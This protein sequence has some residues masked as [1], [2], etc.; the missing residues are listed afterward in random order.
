MN[1]EILQEN[2]QGNSLTS[3]RLIHDTLVC[4]N[5]ARLHTF[6]IPS[7]LRK[8]CTFA[9]TKYKADLEKQRDEKEADKRA[10]KRKSDVEEL[11]NTKKQK[12]L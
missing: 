2:L 12:T 6:T 11:A 5:D 1:K 4:S 7:T 10:L 9:H 8:I 3:Q